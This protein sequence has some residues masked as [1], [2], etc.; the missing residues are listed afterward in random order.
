MALG[1]ET[2]THT[3]TIRKIAGN[4]AEVSVIS[5]AGCISCSLNNACSVSDMKEKMIEVDLSQVAQYNEG[6]NV[7][8]EMKQ[9]YGTWAVLL[10]YLFPFFVLFLGLIMFLHFGLN[11]GLSGI[12]AI[13]LLLPYYGILYL[14]RDFFKKRFRY[15]I[16]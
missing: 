11:Q 15:H 9:S 16:Q 12:L 5:K 14:L 13:A 1:E 6:D 2:V 4:K 10:G 3:G 7:V 8:V